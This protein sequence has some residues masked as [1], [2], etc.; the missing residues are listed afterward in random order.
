MG[1]SLCT[2]ARNKLKHN[3]YARYIDDIFIQMK[4]VNDFIVLKENC[5]RVKY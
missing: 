4:I 3:I 1:S 2:K 5:F